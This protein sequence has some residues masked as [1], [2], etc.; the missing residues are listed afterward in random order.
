MGEKASK[1]VVAVFILI[2]GEVPVFK[3][4]FH[5]ENALKRDFARPIIGEKQKAFLRV[6]KALIKYASASR[7]T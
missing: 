3:A 6:Q 1:T 2:G 7:H 4:V 5:S